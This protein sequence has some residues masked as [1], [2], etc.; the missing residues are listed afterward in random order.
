MSVI[1]N[2]LKDI[3]TDAS[4]AYAKAAVWGSGLGAVGLGVIITPVIHM[5]YKNVATAADWAQLLNAEAVMFP[6]VAAAIAGLVWG[7]A[8]SESVPVPVPVD[9]PDAPSPQ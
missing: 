3:F 9:R 6:T 7:T 5:L 4:G 2:V 1:K 8:K